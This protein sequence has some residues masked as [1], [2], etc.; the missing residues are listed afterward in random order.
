MKKLNE[1][2]TKMI[3]KYFSFADARQGVRDL[4]NYWIIPIYK[5]PDNS[6]SVKVPVA[7]NAEIVAY[8]DKS[9]R[10]YKKIKEH[11]D[12]YYVATKK[13]QDTQKRRRW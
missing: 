1:N 9:G 8:I 13:A 3:G 12:Y 5:E 11:G 7:T 10:R 4:N 2:S 6:F